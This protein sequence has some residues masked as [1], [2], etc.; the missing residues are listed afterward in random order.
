MIVKYILN[1]FT[2]NH[3]LEYVSAKNGKNA[4]KWLGNGTSKKNF[5]FMEAKLNQSVI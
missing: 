3:F 2:A 1:N 4:K 5:N